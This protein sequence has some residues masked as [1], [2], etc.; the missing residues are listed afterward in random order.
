M[1]K[2]SPS[3]LLLAL[4]ITLL[5]ASAWSYHQVVQAEG[6]GPMTCQDGMAGQ[7]PCDGIDYLS[8]MSIEELGG[9]LG[10]GS[11]ANLWGWKDPETNKEYVIFGLT[12]KTAFVDVSDPENP[13]LIGN[14]PNQ[15]TVTPDKY[16]DIKV[17]QN[18]AFIIAD[19]NSEHG[20]QVFDLTELRDVMTPTVTFTTTAYFGEFGNA[21]NL[22]INEDSGY[23]YILRTTAPDL[24][25]SAVY[26]VNIQKPLK[27]TDAGCINDGGAASDTMCVMYHGP[28]PEFQN[29][30]ICATASD[31]NI[32]VHDVSD[33]ANPVLLADLDYS[34]IKRAHNTWFTDDHRYFLSSDMYDETEFGLNMRIFAWDLSDVDNPQLIDIY[35]ADY[36]ASDHNLWIKGDYAYIG[37]FHAGMRML[38]IS[39]LKDGGEM[40]AGPFLDL[41]PKDDNAS[42][43]GGVWAV[44]PFFE[45][46][47]IAIS[48]K[49]AGM[50]LVRPSQDVT[51][52]SV[53]K[54]SSPSNSTG[55]ALAAFALAAGLIALTG[56]TV[57]GKM[58]MK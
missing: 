17:Y 19:E 42:H 46:D 28:D 55:L 12:D 51:A 22:H 3:S 58:G 47:T 49:T 29:K 8:F 27:P 20:M 6:D 9:E 26:M 40:T 23:A 34:N 13:V 14:L 21:H 1:T 39:A 53:S 38:D 25:A 16:R 56:Y 5:L 52:V 11:A 7:Y 24:C 37:N 54:L 31:D 50:Y 44:Y 18:Y 48:D 30:E 32:V 2:K 45:S 41:F 35:D 36:T 15:T 33:K 57:R 43:H 4:A 10:A